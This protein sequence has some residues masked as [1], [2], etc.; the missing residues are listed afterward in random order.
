MSDTRPV[1][2]DPLIKTPEPVET[3]MD[4]PAHVKTYNQF[5][6]LTK[7]FCIHMCALVPA[8]YFFIIAGN[9]TL[10]TVLLLLAIGLL[11]FGLF[12]N[13]KVRQDVAEAAGASEQH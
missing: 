7:W 1:S 10:G 11:I 13:P 5:M 3:G 2:P 4:F 6:N 12:R 9:A 8:L